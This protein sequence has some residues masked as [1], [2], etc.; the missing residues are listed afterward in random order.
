MDQWCLRSVR[1]YGVSDAYRKK[2]R[3]RDGR[4]TV[5]WNYKLYVFREE[6]SLVN[7]KSRYKVEGESASQYLDGEL[8]PPQGCWK[9]KASFKDSGNLKKQNSTLRAVQSIL[10]VQSAS[11]ETVWWNLAH[12]NETNIQQEKRG[13]QY[14]TEI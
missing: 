1:N 14:P 7:L 3:E 9:L 8:V 5:I 4:E 12:S 11:T 10:M 6:G 13:H 2:N